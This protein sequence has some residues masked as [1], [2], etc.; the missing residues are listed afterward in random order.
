MARGTVTL[1]RHYLQYD[2]GQLVPVAMC[3]LNQ[4]EHG[5]GPVDLP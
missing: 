5:P 1:T 3:P 2:S 4:T